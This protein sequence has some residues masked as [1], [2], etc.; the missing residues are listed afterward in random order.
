MIL[1][2]IRNIILVLG[3]L[4]S[5]SAQ[6]QCANL[7]RN[8]TEAEIDFSDLP[9][10]R[11]TYTL[12]PGQVYQPSQ[13]TPM[14]QT[15]QDAFQDDYP[16]V[17]RSR[18]TVKCGANGASSNN[19]VI[20]GLGTWGVLIDAFMFPNLPDVE[21]QSILLQGIT[22]RGF[23]NTLQPNS[24]LFFTAPQG[25]I[26]LK[27]CIFEDVGSFAPFNF[28]QAF[29]ETPNRALRNEVAEVP[30]SE[31]DDD[32]KLK[33]WMDAYNSTSA[34]INAHKILDGN[35]RRKVLA[36]AG[37]H[38]NIRRL[39]DT[40]DFP[41]FEEG[42]VVIKIE[43]CVFANTTM[44]TTPRTDSAHTLL[45]F[46]GILVTDLEEPTPGKMN[47]RITGT[48]FQN[49][50]SDA[51]SPPF[52]TRRSIIEFQSNGKLFLQ[53]TCFDDI[54][55]PSFDVE[56]VILMHANS[57]H[58]DL[59]GNSIANV[60]FLDGDTP[61][62]NSGC[63]YVALYN[64]DNILANSYGFLTCIDDAFNFQNQCGG[65][66]GGGGGGQPS[67]PLGI[68]ICFSS[69]NTAQLANGEKKNFDQL[70]LG[71]K[72]LTQKG[73]ETIYSFGH[74]SPKEQAQFVQLLPSRIELSSTHLIF[75]EDGR[76]VTAESV[77]VGDILLSGELVTGKRYV[78]SQGLFA[79]FT[80][81]GTIIANGQVASSYV[82]LQGTP[83]LEINGWSTG[84][85]YQWMAHAFE[86]PHRLWCLMMRD[87]CLK[88]S[89]TSDGISTWVSI[90]QK[91]FLWYL[92]SHSFTQA[93]LVVPILSVFGI[94]SMIGYM[95][96]DNQNQVVTF[97]CLVVSV[98]YVF[99][100]CRV[101]KMK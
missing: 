31:L 4:V 66:G 86:V 64:L 1:V 53:D 101:R 51:D 72:V 59:G 50:K 30:Y 8:I 54:K 60:E 3:L 77:E 23:V 55:I 18:A 32:T 12:C 73:F 33:L 48:K 67:P 36:D 82:S 85:S 17:V 47:V 58:K 14:A 57:E 68:A 15:L 81:S 49:I 35:S 71:D 95:T 37:V 70:Q 21:R 9:G 25:S 87:V 34:V 13:L 88:E 40:F 79:P 27:D 83:E 20:D 45:Y 94:L 89:Y 42:K 6:L 99:S 2:R 69:E 22:F 74:Y 39:N 97:T 28:L 11:R 43:D 100:Q 56:A 41:D 65:G 96:V 76:A 52:P 29:R 26:T 84:F 63:N 92:Q 98:A 38:Q 61:N 90:P 7:L 93:L 10:G 24:V 62:P 80:A 44:V 16:L 46:S 19:C 78:T 91:F 5:V 75:L